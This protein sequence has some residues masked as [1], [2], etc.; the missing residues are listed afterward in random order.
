MQIFKVLI[1]VLMVFEPV[2]EGFFFYQYKDFISALPAD[3]RQKSP[4]RASDRA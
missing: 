2:R 4:R 3:V 1:I